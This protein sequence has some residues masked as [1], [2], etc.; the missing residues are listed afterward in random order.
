MQIFLK[1]FGSP[2]FCEILRKCKLQ[3]LSLTQAQVLSLLDGRRLTKSE[4]AIAGSMSLENARKTIGYLLETGD[5]SKAGL[6]I[7]R[8]RAVV[9]YELSPQG[10]NMVNRFKG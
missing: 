1:M 6:K 9:V 3:G 5:V 2:R 7:Y 4:L 8:G 10:Q